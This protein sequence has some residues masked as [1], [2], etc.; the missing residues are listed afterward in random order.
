MM[1]M[2]CIDL[3]S[4]IEYYESK[5]NA[6]YSVILNDSLR[7]FQSKIQCIDLHVNSYD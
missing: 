2:Y 3:Q 1:G 7:V 6:N 4:T 5:I